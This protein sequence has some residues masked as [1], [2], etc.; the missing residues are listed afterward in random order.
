[1]HIGISAKIIV[2]NFVF[3]LVNFTFPLSDDKMVVM[4]YD[5][6]RWQIT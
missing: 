5:R 4:Y 2:F 6:N 3:N 1:V